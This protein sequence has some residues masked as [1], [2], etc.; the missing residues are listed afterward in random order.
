MLPLRNTSLLAT[1]IAGA[2]LLIAAMPASGHEGVVTP[3]GDYC[4]DC[5]TY[6]TCKVTLT[7]REAVTALRGYYQERGYRLGTVHHRGRFIEADVYKDGAK[8]DRVLFDRKSGRLRSV[9]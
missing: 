6:G 7:P 4:R 1:L 5:T 8:V 2:A 9:Y 3:Y